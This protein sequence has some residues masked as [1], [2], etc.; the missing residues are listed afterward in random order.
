MNPRTDALSRS[1]PRRRPAR[2]PLPLGYGWAWTLLG[3]SGAGC[4]SPKD[5]ERPHVEIAAS[6]CAYCHEP[7]YAA[8]KHP[9]HRTGDKDLYPKTCGSCHE[10]KR[11]RPAHF[12]HPFPL[13]GQHALTACW[14]CH[15][16]S[17][18]VFAGTPRECLGC[19]VGDFASSNFP[20]H[21]AFQATCLDCHTTTGWQPATGPHPEDLFAITSGPHQ[22]ACLDCH[23]RSRGDN[24]AANTN[25]VGCHE[26]VHAREV[27]DPV[28]QELGL[29]D[30]PTG[31]APPNFCLSCH[32]S[33]TL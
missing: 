8:A 19:H 30:Y 16:G 32:P 24:G 22:Y 10:T 33:G 21:S 12:A 14:Q 20:G 27:L 9:L 29:S 18:P 31:D 7:D 26:G 13:D 17:P 23:D 3:L 2:S 6:D 15:V 1:S 25:C 28:H 5:F 4:E 11:F